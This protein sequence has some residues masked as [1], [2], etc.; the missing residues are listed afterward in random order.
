MNP[1][2]AGKRAGEGM[3][4]FSKYANLGN[5]EKRRRIDQVLERKSNVVQQV[6]AQNDVQSNRTKL[7][8][9]ARGDMPNSADLPQPKAIAR[10]PMPAKRKA[11]EWK[12]KD[13]TKMEKAIKSMGDRPPLRL[14]NA[15][16]IKAN[17]CE[18][19][20]TK[21]QKT[22]VNHVKKTVTSDIVR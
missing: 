4:P 1:F 10:P 20:T 8:P 12:L 21:K 3:R 18:Q 15:D 16:Y 5:A 6:E 13:K 11:Q 2:A 17:K 14:F 22:E 9:F 7:R 19:A